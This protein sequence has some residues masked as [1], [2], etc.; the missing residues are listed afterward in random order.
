MFKVG[1][2]SYIDT[3]E[4]FNDFAFKCNPMPD[5]TCKDPKEIMVIKEAGKFGATTETNE[6]ASPKEQAF[7]EEYSVAGWF[8][9]KGTKMDPWHLAFR[10]H[11]NQGQDN[12]NVAKL[13]DRTLALWPSNQGVYAFATYSYTNLNGAG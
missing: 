10:L 12:G 1:F 6:I 13:G 8:K 2:G 3:K 5:V 9:W 11:I 7:P 4:G